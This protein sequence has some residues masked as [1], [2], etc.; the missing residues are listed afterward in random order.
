MMMMMIQDFFIKEKMYFLSGDA[1]Q[2]L[3]IC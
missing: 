2:M 1:G 3:G